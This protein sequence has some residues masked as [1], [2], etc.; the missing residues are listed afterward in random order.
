MN[1]TKESQMSEAQA[2]YSEAYNDAAVQEE[3]LGLPEEAPFEVGEEIEVGDLSRVQRS[4]LPAA[5]GVRFEVQSTSIE[6]TKSGY[7]KYLKAKLKVLGIPSQNEEGE[8]VMTHA[9]KIVFPGVMDLCIWHDPN[10]PDPKGWWKAQDAGSREY[11][12]GIK[13]FSQACGFNVSDP[14]FKI[15]DAYHLACA[16][17]VILGTISH[18]TDKQT[19]QVSEKFGNWKAA[20]AEEV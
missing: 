18:E 15:N 2:A 12:L 9:G 14:K 19:G 1:T 10:G 17:K 3:A 7:I 6:K 13:Q 4:V 5:K 16:G 8:L 11:Q 20:P